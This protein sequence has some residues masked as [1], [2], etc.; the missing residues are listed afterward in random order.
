MNINIKLIKVKVFFEY[1]DTAGVSVRR[2]GC[3]IKKQ[4]KYITHVKL[5]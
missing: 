3:Y 1:F 2:N 4:I 5:L